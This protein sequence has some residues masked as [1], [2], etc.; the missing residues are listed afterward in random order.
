MK[1][2]LLL[3]I[4][5]LSVCS[6]FGDSI[7]ITN[8]TNL[9]AF[10]TMHS[11]NAIQGPFCVQPGEKIFAHAV[12]Y[13]RMLAYVVH[14][15]GTKENCFI[16]R[17]LQENIRMSWPYDHIT[18]IER[19]SNSNLCEGRNF[20]VKITPD[21][22][23]RAKPAQK[24]CSKKPRP[25]PPVKKNQKLLQEL[26]SL[27]SLLN[28]LN[29][30]VKTIQSQPVTINNYSFLQGSLQKLDKKILGVLGQK[31]PSAG[32]GIIASLKKRL[33]SVWTNVRNNMSC[34]GNSSCSPE[35]RSAASKSF[36]RVFTIATIFI[37]AITAY[38]LRTKKEEKKTFH[39]SPFYKPKGVLP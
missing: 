33:A 35:E 38:L 10:F 34:I 32:T 28:S 30:D 3:I 23:S 9:T 36:L 29:K 11:R 20:Q 4:S 8:K 7:K 2:V 27:K 21:T 17:D 15:D 12:T 18:A 5:S 31:D 22:R 13:V 39:Y 19:C 6:I 25:G 24:L 14:D 26:E 1:K 37:S 16:D